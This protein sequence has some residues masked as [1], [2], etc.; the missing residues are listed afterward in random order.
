[1]DEENGNSPKMEF[2][3]LSGIEAAIFDMDGTMINNMGHHKKAWL[4]FTRRHGISFTEEEFKERFSGKKND[5]I[6]SEIFE[7]E[8]TPEEIIQYGSEKEAVYREL[9]APDIK[10]VEGLKALIK[11]LREKGLKLAIATTAPEANR[12]FGLEALGLSD[13]FDL[14]LGEEHV[15]QGKPHPEIY[16]KTAEELKVNPSSCIVFEDSPPGVASGKSAGM[17]VIGLLTS[18]TSEDLSDAD[19]HIKDFSRLEI[20]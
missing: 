15:T 5:Q 2:L 17:K 16:L 4:E 9:Y 8:L 11:S 12:N 19:L 20:K 14:I 1:M 6:L 7:R 18:H 10:E 3:D 13:A